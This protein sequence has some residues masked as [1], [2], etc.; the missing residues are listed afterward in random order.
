M[1]NKEY[2]TWIDGEQPSI[3]HI[4][5]LVDV[6]EVSK[7]IIG[8]LDRYREKQQEQKFLIYF[9]FRKHDDQCSTVAAMLRTLLLQL[10][11][12][13]EDLYHAES[14]PFEEL[15]HY[16]NWTQTDLLLLFRSILSSW[17]HG[18][19]LCVI[20]NMGECDSPGLAFLEDICSLARHIERRFDIAITSTT[21]KHLQEVLAG[22]P[23]I[24]L[25][26]HQEDSASNIALEVSELL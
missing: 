15:S 6:S 18:D 23:T 17:D 21:D 8:C 3:L 11:N 25:E 24:N 9:T 2:K 4:H 12:E 13:C 10:F 14:L 19:T 5:G 26:D 16:S 22:W 1:A 20:N 7:V